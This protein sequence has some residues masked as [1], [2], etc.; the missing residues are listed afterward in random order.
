MADKRITELPA[1]T[2]VSAGKQLAMDDLITERVTIQQLVDYF[3]TQIEFPTGGSPDAYALGVK[4]LSA[5]QLYC[6]AQIMRAAG[7]IA[8]I[9]A[10]LRVDSGVQLDSMASA[11]NWA[12]TN[13][14]GAN[15]AAITTDYVEGG[16][17]LSIDKTGTAAASAGMK[18]VNIASTN[19][20]D[21]K[22]RVTVKIPAIASGTLSSVRVWVASGGAL[23]AY[24]YW[25]KTTDVAG[26]TLVAG[27]GG[28]YTIEIDPGAAGDG[29]GGS[30]DK[31]ATTSV[32]VELVLSS[33]SATFSGFLVD[34]VVYTPGAAELNVNVMKRN[35]A[36]GD[37][38]LYSTGDS[39]TF[40]GLRAGL[41]VTKDTNLQNATVAKDDVLY[42]DIPTSGSYYGQDLSVIVEMAP[43]E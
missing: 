13:A 33:T 2:V 8:N 9:R 28:K 36:G 35:V 20:T 11:T 25:D 30:Y 3:L 40:P 5:A 43:E 1:A 41:I 21:K 39:Y 16:S 23:T 10:F 24:K 19:L 32:A 34:H 42:L 26:S 12:A 7:T 31:T 37:V 6:S 18:R 4:Y 15:L 27:S 22:V 14:D 17:C 38:L 29:S